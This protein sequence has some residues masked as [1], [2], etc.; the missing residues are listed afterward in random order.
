MKSRSGKVPVE[1]RILKPDKE[2]VYC[3]PSIR[4]GYSFIEGCID[5]SSRQA[6]IKLSRISTNKIINGEW[7]LIAADSTRNQQY[8][9][10]YPLDQGVQLRTKAEGMSVLHPHLQELKW[11]LNNQ[12]FKYREEG[13]IIS[14]W[15]DGQGRQH[16]EVSHHPSED[17][18]ILRL[19]ENPGVVKKIKCAMLGGD[20]LNDF[21]QAIVEIKS[22]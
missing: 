3:F 22:L 18:L 9:M 6:H 2:V 21:A 8:L 4:A 16:V 15:L 5:L 7:T 19:P 10:R 14:L 12:G 13:D 17:Y 1:V 20:R 11:W